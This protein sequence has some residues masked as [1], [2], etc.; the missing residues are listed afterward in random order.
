MSKVVESKN[1]SS[2]LIVS[3]AIA[4]KKVL[5]VGGDSIAASRA[6]FAAEAGAVVSVVTPFASLSPSLKSVL[7]GSTASSTSTASTTPVQWFDRSFES[8]DLDGAALVFVCADSSVSSALARQIGSLAKEK[9][10]PVNVAALPELSDFFFMSTYKD[11]SLQVAI[12]TNGNGPRLAAKLRKQIV[13]SIPAH[14]GS[15][16]EVLAKL[17][18]ALKAADPSQ[19]SN[20][21]RMAFVNKVSETWSVETL[22]SFTESEVSALVKAYQSQSVDLPRVKQ[23]SLRVIRTGS[24]SVEDLTVGAYRAL[25]EAELVLSDSAVPKEFL[26]LV[27]GDLMVVPAEAERASDTMIVA[28]IRAL[29][30][31]QNVI[32]LRVGSDA[33]SV[34]ED[35]ELN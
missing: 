35:E 32:R 14:A 33:I 7:S 16:L 34:S 30:L 25:S 19:A 13:N 23:G 1:T 27:N 17:R 18:N 10:V 4:G 20:A 21:R 24:G 5:V 6:V 8:K 15:A 22:A 31:G 11:Q 29:E 28:A 2:S 12:S 26:D 3:W 9:G